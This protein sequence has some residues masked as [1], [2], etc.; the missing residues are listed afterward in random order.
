MSIASVASST[1]GTTSTGTTSSTSA[2]STSDFLA[3][4]V[5]QL[6]NQNPLDPTDTS[7]FMS[8]LTSYASYDQQ[9]EMN[10]Q[11]GDLVSSVNSLLSTNAVTYVGKTVEAYGDTTSLTDGSAT[12]GY[13]LETDATDVAITI[14]D[15]DG[16]VVYETTGETAAGEHSFTWDGKKAD[17]TQCEDGAYTIEVEATDA[18]G[19]AVYGYTTVTGT[20]TGVDSSSGTV[21][22]SIG[23]VQV[24][25]EDVF[26]VKA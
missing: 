18:S 6:Q 5:T 11:L 24:A 23:D 2:L 16:N 22:L 19:D 8:Q 10:E 1:S 7:E 15:A 13:S 25:F 3:L 17:G 21:L 9:L 12:W 14:K 20:V 4:M 26:G